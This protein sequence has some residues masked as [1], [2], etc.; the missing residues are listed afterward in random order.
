M[1]DANA[2]PKILTMVA[3]VLKSN[4]IYVVLLSNVLECQNGSTT[5]ELR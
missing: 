1:A 3:N 5:F 4:N 2:V